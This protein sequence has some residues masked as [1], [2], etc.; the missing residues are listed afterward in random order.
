MRSPHTVGNKNN[1]PHKKVCIFRFFMLLFTLSP[2]KEPE[3][4]P[5]LCK[6]YSSASNL[7][8]SRAISGH[9]AAAVFLPV[10]TSISF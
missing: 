2:K 8:I 7:F 6:F 5:A 4:K 10:H 3:K 9:S 1:Q